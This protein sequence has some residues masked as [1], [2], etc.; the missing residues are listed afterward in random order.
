MI[1]TI[2][3]VGETLFDREEFPYASL[4]AY[5]NHPNLSEFPD[6]HEVLVAFG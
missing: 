1:F 6:E 4:K 2:D 5:L 3:L